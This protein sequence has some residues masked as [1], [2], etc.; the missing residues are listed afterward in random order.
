MLTLS[1]QACW[2]SPSRVFVSRDQRD[3]LV[4]LA[5]YANELSGKSIQIRAEFELKP[6]NSSN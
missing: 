4:R 6:C 2:K 5:N 3:N 1:I